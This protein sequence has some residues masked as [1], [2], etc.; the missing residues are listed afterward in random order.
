M[1]GL[2]GPPVTAIPTPSSTWALITVAAIRYSGRAL[3]PIRLASG[4]YASTAT[5]ISASGHHPIHGTAT[6]NASANDPYM[7]AR[8][9][10]SLA[11]ISRRR[12]RCSGVGHSQVVRSSIH[13][14]IGT[15][16]PIR[17][18]PPYDSPSS[19]DFASTSIPCRRARLPPRILR[20][21]CS[22]SCG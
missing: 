1:A 18:G 14:V 3:L 19:F 22:V 13:P 2:C 4:A 6:R 10:P 21:A 5:Q 12:S 8:G 9:R 20:L 15:T 7:S 17:S 11:S 16:P